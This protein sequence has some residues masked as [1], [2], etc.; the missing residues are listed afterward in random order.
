[1]NEKIQMMIR[2]TKQNRKKLRWEEAIDL[3]KDTTRKDLM[4]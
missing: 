3:M 2:Q 4:I 1:M